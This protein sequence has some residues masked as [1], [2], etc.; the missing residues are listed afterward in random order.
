MRPGNALHCILLNWSYLIQ[1]RA[2]LLCLY[3]LSQSSNI[4]T[5]K[6]D[7]PQGLPLPVSVPASPLTTGLAL[8]GA[9]QTT[10]SSDRVL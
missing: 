2:A 10:D 9:T 5:I 1:R 6:Q 8:S 7:L 3:L 4:V